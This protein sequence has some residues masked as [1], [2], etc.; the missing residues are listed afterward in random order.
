MTLFS[1]LYAKHSRSIH[2]TSYSS[3][4]LILVRFLRRYKVPLTRPHF[5]QRKKR[6]MK[7]SLFSKLYAK[8]FSDMYSLRA[9]YR[10]IARR[11]KSNRSKFGT[12]K[13]KPTRRLFFN[14]D[15]LLTSITSKKHQQ[16]RKTEIIRKTRIKLE[17]ISSRN[18]RRRLLRPFIKYF[19]RQRLIRRHSF[20]R[21][22]PNQVE[23]NLIKGRFFR[24]AKRINYKK[25]SKY[26]RY[27]AGIHKHLK[28]RRRFIKK[29]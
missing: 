20:R 11:R 24:I 3:R 9:I 6:K 27:R 29:K 19:L 26:K 7:M 16:I 28:R 25:R 2:L 12:Y 13:Y 10:K 15:F 1:N 22:K 14:K 8:H 18:K 21:P 4:V 17:N 23:K 5:I